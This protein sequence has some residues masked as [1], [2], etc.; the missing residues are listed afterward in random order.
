[1][2]KTSKRALAIALSL[3]MIAGSNLSVMAATTNPD[4]SDREIQHKTDA[5]NIAA[6]GMVLLEN[7][8][9]ALPISAVPGRK[10]A[11]KA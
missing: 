5:K 6:Q 8:S 10:R 7:E 2:K 4:I 1:M 3:S 11:A 9:G